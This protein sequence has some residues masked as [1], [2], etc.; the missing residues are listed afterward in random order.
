MQDWNARWHETWT[1]LDLAPP[2]A[3]LARLLERYREPGR[4]Y[5]TLQ[6]LDECFAAFDLLRGEARRPGEI[7][8][9][10]WFHDAVYDVRRHDNEA[11]SAALALECLAGADDDLRGRVA[12]LI[13]AT[14]HHGTGGGAD[15]D[16][17]NDSAILLDIDLAILG[18]PA[19]RFA[20]YEAQIRAEYAHVPADVYREK[21][22]EVL[23]GFLERPRLY[24]TAIFHET[25]EDQARANLAASLRD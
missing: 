5:H 16:D 23:R 13:L 1:L 15:K 12:A 14:R 3:W 6:H 25:I 17:D 19:R 10:L 24:A 8:L 18:A 4:H 11:E 7:A 21:R 2:A 22:R 20:E 9:A